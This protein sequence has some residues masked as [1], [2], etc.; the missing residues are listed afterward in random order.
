[1]ALGLDPLARRRVAAAHDVPGSPMD[2]IVIAWVDHGHEIHHRTD[3]VGLARR[4]PQQRMTEPRFHAGQPIGPRAAEQVQKRMVSAWSSMVCPVATSRAGRQSGPLGRAPL[5][6]SDRPQPPRSHPQMSPQ[7]GAWPPPTPPLLHPP[8]LPGVRD[9]RDA[10]SRRIP[11][12]WRAPT[13]PANRAHLRRHR[14]GVRPVGGRCSASRGRAI[15][16][17]H[18]ACP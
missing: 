18:G 14:E 1:M 7:R 13:T 4:S 15:S 10:R 2:G 9:Q 5:P 12:R 16:S 8:R 17:G 11:P 6:G 3:G